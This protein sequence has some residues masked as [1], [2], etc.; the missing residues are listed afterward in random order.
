[1]ILHTVYLTGGFLP[2]THPTNTSLPFSGV[3]CKS[4]ES[5]IVLNQQALL[6]PCFQIMIWGSWPQVEKFTS[7]NMWQR[8][9]FIFSF[10]STFP[11]LQRGQHICNQDVKPTESTAAV[12]PPKP[13]L[14]VRH[15]R[16]E[17]SCCLL[18][19]NKYLWNSQ[20][21]HFKRHGSK[22]QFLRAY[23]ACIWSWS[24]LLCAGSLPIIPLEMEA[25][26]KLANGQTVFPLYALWGICGSVVRQIQ[27]SLNRFATMD[28]IFF[29][30]I[31]ISP[32]HS[33]DYDTF[34]CFVS[35]WSIFY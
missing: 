4:W 26:K 7:Q 23:P 9:F 11:F 1:M 2:P 15:L 16:T 32:Q 22:K 19:D 10:F 5:H 33:P 24:N 3:P 21:E 14:I 18:P 6:R 31:I 30:G 29:N 17:E 25:Q 20:A 8:Q 12:I 13:S 35:K 27:N 34:H 28:Q